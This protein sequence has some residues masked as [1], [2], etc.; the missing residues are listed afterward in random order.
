MRTTY[1]YGVF[2]DTKKWWTM[3]RNRKHAVS[4]AK[5]CGGNG[6]VTRMMLPTTRSWDAPTFRACSDLLFD[7][8]QGEKNGPSV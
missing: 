3:T 5:E 7:F 6:Y 1:L 2:D 8:R 4:M